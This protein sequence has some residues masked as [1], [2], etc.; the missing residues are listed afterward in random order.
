MMR[1]GG[2]GGGGG[3]AAAPSF[4]VLSPAGARVLYEPQAML[5]SPPPSRA[6]EPYKVAPVQQHSQ[7]ARSQRKSS[8]AI[9]AE[10]RAPTPRA[11]SP[12]PAS[13]PTSPGGVA[14]GRLSPFRGRGF[15][16]P[17]PRSR[18]SGTVHQSPSGRAAS[19]YNNNNN[20]N[21]SQ[22]G[23][24]RHGSQI[25]RP[26]RSRSIS[27]SK[28]NE[29]LDSNNRASPK[30]GRRA[31][32]RYNSSM[33]S[34][35]Q[36]HQK[37][38][39]G[40][41]G[42]GGSEHYAA[43]R[44][45]QYRGQQMPKSPGVAVIKTPKPAPRSSMLGRDGRTVA[46]SP[47]RAKRNLLAVPPKNTGQGNK[48][49]VTAKA[50]PSDNKNQSKAA[51]VPATPD[52]P[53]RIPLRQQQQQQQQQ[54]GNGTAVAVSDAPKVTATGGTA[55]KPPPAPTINGAK[56]GRNNVSSIPE[57]VVPAERN[58]LAELLKQSSVAAGGASSVVNT[59]TAT[60]VQPLQIDA[61]AV[62]AEAEL[63]AKLSALEQQQKK[64]KDENKPAG[65]PL[66]TISRPS[67]TPDSLTKGSTNAAAAAQSPASQ[68]TKTQ[69]MIKHFG[70]GATGATNDTA[71]TTEKQSNQGAAVK[72][73]TPTTTADDQTDKQSQSSKS[74]TRKVVK[75]ANGAAAAATAAATATASAAA[76]SNGD[77]KQ[78]SLSSSAAPSPSPDADPGAD[79]SERQVRISSDSP[80]AGS[81]RSSDTG[82][83]VDTVKGGGNNATGLSSAKERSGLLIKRPE[84]IET[85]SGNVVR[86]NGSEHNTAVTKA[87][88]VYL[89]LTLLRGSSYLATV[90][91]VDQLDQSATQGGG[92]SSSPG[93]GGNRW[94]RIQAFWRRKLGRSKKKKPKVRPAAAGGGT[95]GEEG[96]RPA[97]RSKLDLKNCWSQMRCLACRRDPKAAVP[98]PGKRPR[99][100]S[101]THL[102]EPAESGGGGGGV[103]GITKESRWARIRRSCRC[104]GVNKCWPSGAA[105]AGA[106]AGGGLAAWRRRHKPSQIAPQPAGASR[107]TGCCPPERRPAALCRSFWSKICC[108][109]NCCS[110]PSCLGKKAAAQPRR[111][112]HSIAS[113]AAAPP[114]EENRPKLPDVLVEHGSVMRGAIPCLPVILA[115]LC[116]ICNVCIPGSGTLL[117][118]LF[119][120]CCGQPRFSATASPKARVGALVVDALVGVSQ[121]FTV[122]FCLVGWGWSIW[123]G[124][125]MVRVARKWKRFKTSEAAANDP[126]A[127]NG[128]EQATLPAPGVQA[129]Q[130]AERAAA[131]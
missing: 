21:Q 101:S 57:E 54:R 78:A 102:T 32:R 77:S 45:Q 36:Q 88:G 25:P 29:R 75:V 22:H 85:L 26:A 76:S 30:F 52:S 99:G 91:G 7:G 56:D 67:P 11:L 16:G 20:N 100:A 61:A 130:S 126:E 118:G 71:T 104:R 108:S 119:N 24:P 42:G 33:V 4:R 46:P 96:E 84:E 49:F 65:S 82:V 90:T 128:P 10:A 112:K 53:S 116:L 17:L 31:A 12:S 107:G 58:N 131:R 106:G 2:G 51:A 86:R 27:A 55:D 114:S 72:A 5:R 120:L 62:L 66:V 38:N 87:K 80:A 127:R 92:D 123:W 13:R 41:I 47:E 89:I 8:F 68:E 1:G 35:Q 109:C 98:W 15:R 60:A 95:D 117:A 64:E 103:K 28:E 37:Q 113:I 121:L 81:Y 74:L 6:P 73:S 122:L 59:T 34:Q 94:Q 44:R 105:A 97:P 50:A 18:S 93:G 48:R 79:G 39:G 115:W 69:T 125:T 70:T 83:S 110:R 9:I 124:V 23:S 40:G 3:A 43:G 111:S 129:F 63:V 14:S 19:R